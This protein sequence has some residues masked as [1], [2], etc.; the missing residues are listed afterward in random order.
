M[1]NKV[2]LLFSKSKV[3]VHPTSSS[4]DNIPGF[5]AI[6]RSTTGSGSTSDAILIS[7]VPEDSLLEKNEVDSYIKVDLQDATPELGPSMEEVLVSKPTGH[8]ILSYAF[9]IPLTDVYSVSVRPPSVG[10]WYGSIIIH[11]KREEDTYPALFFHDSE[12]KSTMLIKRAKS[13]AFEP[14][15]QDSSDTVTHS[16]WGGDQFLKELGKYATIQKSTLEPQIFLV[17]PSGDDLLSFSPKVTEKNNQFSFIALA[18]KFKWK[19]LENLARLTHTSRQVALGAYESAPESVK[20]WIA[21]PEVKKIGDEF[22]SARVY[23]AKWALNLAEEAERERHRRKQ[24]ILD[25]SPN[26]YLES[27]LGGFE[28]VDSESQYR[29]QKPVTNDE[30]RSFFDSEGYPKVTVLEIKERLFHGGLEPEARP[31]AWLYLLNVIPWNVSNE[32]RE[33]ILE[34]KRAEYLRLKRQWWEDTERQ[35]NDFHFK[36]QKSRIEKD[37]QRTDR[38]IEMFA[39][40][41]YELSEMETSLTH[42]LTN[43]HLEQLKALLITYNEYNTSLGYVQGMSDLLAPLYATIQDDSLTF[44]A[45]VGF[46]ERMERNFLRNQEGMRDQLKTL[47]DLVMFMEPALFDHLENA[48]ST[49]LFFF[50]RMILVWFKREFEWDDV[51][52]LW[53]VLWTDYLSSQFHIFVALAILVKHKTVIIENLRQFDEILKYM[54]DLSNNINLDETLK[55]AESLYYRF[56]RTVE[57]VDIQNRDHAEAEDYRPIEVSDNLRSLLKKQVITVK[58]TDDYRTYGA[59]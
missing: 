34:S 27:S 54:N 59:N 48:N 2:A 42:N 32:E 49:N 21:T 40:E 28:I 55:T 31:I 50:F 15:A 46:M 52:R 57:I 24:L 35:T 14:F 29:R 20:R 12:S 43:A 9:S 56:A 51:L 13:Q 23:L 41:D 37:V 22:E 10:L 38:N 8:S 4:K 18:N 25:D 19:A 39:P 53:E 45:F 6:V 7:W 11:S 3:Y 33:V 26:Q 17:N 47:G 58:E 44:W 30:W 36:D 1:S 16:F 5:L